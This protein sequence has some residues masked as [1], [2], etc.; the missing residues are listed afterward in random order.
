MSFC[1]TAVCECRLAETL[2]LAELITE[3]SNVTS[4]LTQRSLQ[5]CSLTALFL[6]SEQQI[7]YITV[8]IPS[9]CLRG[10]NIHKCKSRSD[11]RLIFANQ[12]LD[13]RGVFA[14]LDTRI[15]LHVSFLCLPF[16]F[17]DVA[18]W[19]C[20]SG[21]ETPHPFGHPGAEEEGDR[22]HGGRSGQQ[23]V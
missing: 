4:V 15:H 9:Q 13:C 7:F 3:V 18:G 6:H 22:G 8:A 10:A 5:F 16:C 17:M 2:C 23:E 19:N 20:G 21:R 11:R 14:H 12:M 1:P